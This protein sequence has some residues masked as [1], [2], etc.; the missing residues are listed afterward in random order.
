MI[1]T[2]RC[3]RI[4][5]AGRIEC[6]KC[7]QTTEFPDSARVVVVDLGSRQEVIDATTTDVVHHCGRR[8]WRA[9]ELCGENIPRTEWQKY[10]GYGRRTR[11]RHIITDECSL[12]GGTIIQMSEPRQMVEVGSSTG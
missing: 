3:A 2:V 10:G 11:T 8:Y 1:V 9:C 4:D 12:C 5:G 6:R 7:D